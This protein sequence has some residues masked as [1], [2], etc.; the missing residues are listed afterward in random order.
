MYTSSRCNPDC[1][2]QIVTI[3]R[4]NLF[5]TYTTRNIG[6][7]IQ[8]KPFGIESLWWLVA[9]YMKSIKYL[10][11]HIKFV[12]SFQSSTFQDLKSLIMKTQRMR[13]RRGLGLWRRRQLMPQPSLGILWPRGVEGTARW[14]L[15]QSRIALTLRKCRRWMHFAKH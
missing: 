14:C 7:V 2:C 9:N 5:L 10:H 11:M 15:F 12:S 3:H 6:H 13:G 4:S 8:K 1:F